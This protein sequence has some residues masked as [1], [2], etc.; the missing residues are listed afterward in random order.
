MNLREWILEKLNP[1]QPAI[2]QDAGSEVPNTSNTVYYATAYQDID[3]VRRGVD[4]IVN[5]AASFDITVTEQL[6]G[7][8]PIVLGTRAK[9]LHNLLNHSPNPFQD[10]NSF[11]RLIF[12]D[13]IL[14]GNA[15]IFV[16]NNEMY[17][18]PSS[19]V[20][21]IPDPVTYV[22]SYE[23]SNTPKPLN[24]NSVI[25]IKDNS[26]TTIYRGTTRLAAAE[27][28]IKTLLKMTN[29]QHNFF[30]NGAVPGLVLT[31]ENV[32]GEQAKLR[33]LNVW[34][35]RYNPKSGGRRPMILDGGLKVDS[36]SDTNFSELDFEN[37]IANKE[38]TI[39]KALGVP[40]ILLDGGNNANIAPNLKL[41]YLE[42]VLP[43]VRAYTS[44]LER[45]FGYDLEAET[46][47]ISALQPQMSEAAGFYT[48]LVNGGV[49]TPNEAR[50]ELRW[51][52]MDDP[53]MDEIREPKNIAGSAVDPTEGGRPPAP[54]K[55]ERG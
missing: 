17:H 6:K 53:K 55:D 42:T 49:I 28:S 45:Y 29:F 35:Q 43:V 26:S 27:S 32:L 54:K 1:V 51:E 38:R 39:L 16:E 24:V 3:V 13:L 40:P 50:V 18:L 31:S 10:I 48:S 52:P 5:A 15:F 34:A 21:V 19:N 37:S 46:E 41:F 12:I 20:T 22:N 11:R 14:E 47:K 7:V 36:L 4:M 33:M 2:A 44:A 23:Y 9:T 25:H 30:D 8:A